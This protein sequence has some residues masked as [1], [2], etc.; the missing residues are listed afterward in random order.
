MV[1]YSVKG[2]SM[3]VAEQM[4]NL[5]ELIE[6]ADE[7]LNDPAVSQKDKDS[8]NEMRASAVSAYLELHM[9]VLEGGPF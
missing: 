7:Y 9:D 6:D 5:I 1:T 3:S 4:E 2:V 8:A